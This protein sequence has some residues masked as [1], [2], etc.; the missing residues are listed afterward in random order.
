MKVLQTLPQGDLNNV[1][2]AAKAAEAAGFDM[3]VTMENR[4]D[5]FLSL[6]IAAIETERV[7]LGT[8]IAIAFARLRLSG[9]A[10]D[11]VRLHPFCT[12]AYLED[13]VMRRIKE[14]FDK[15]GRMRDSFEVTG[16]GFIATGETEDDVQKV[17]EWVRHRIAFYG[18][19]PSYWPVLEHH[20]YGDLGRKLNRMT[21]DGKW[22]EIVNEIPDDVLHLFAVI[23]PFTQLES[24][25]VKRFGG[26]VDAIYASTSQDIRP[27]IPSDV[28]Q[29]IAR[30]PTA[31]SGFKTIW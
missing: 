7:K 5:P 29:D 9:E 23:A 10:C 16:G 27:Q 17:A 18:S 13:I 26:T 31:F 20:G 24:A 19:T 30:I 3:V 22:N 2:S 6:G 14:G 12:R 1:P 21:K 25:I 28:L 15:T 8:A 11:G 4:H